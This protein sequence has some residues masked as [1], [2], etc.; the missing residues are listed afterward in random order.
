MKRCYLGAKLHRLVITEANPDYIGSITLDRDLLDLS[1]IRE[2]EKVLVGDLENGNRFET[3]VI[4]GQAG[5]GIVC[6][7][8]AAAK[9]VSPGDRIIVM[10]FVWIEA[11]E[12]VT[13]PVIVIADDRNLNPVLLKS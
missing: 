11:D 8:G 12:E 4:E 1:G 2:W 3:Y 6:I 13:E 9:L 10:Q 5:S 7:N